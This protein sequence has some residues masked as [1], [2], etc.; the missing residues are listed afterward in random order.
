MSTQ[1]GGLKGLLQKTGKTIFSAV[2]VIR[3]CGTMAARWS[4]K[5]GGNVAF[6][7]ATTSMVVLMPLIFESTREVQVCMVARGIWLSFQL[8]LC[9]VFLPILPKKLPLDVRK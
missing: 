5:V 2:V 4:Y 8:Q 6:V 3:D 7:M 1:S 9:F